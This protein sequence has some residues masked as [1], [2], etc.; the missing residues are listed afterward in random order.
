MTGEA[1][2]PAPDQVIS[3]PQ[4]EPWNKGGLT[5]Q[6]RPL[7]PGDAWTIRVRL[8]LESRK[9]DLAMCNLRIDSK[10]RGCDHVRLQVNALRQ[11]SR[12]SKRFE[13][14][15]ETADALVGRSGVVE[16]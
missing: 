7:K 12:L 10:L 4:R 1:L 13:P 16:H 9:R 3:A 11:P 8:Q 2:M 14:R 15:L 6:K 5:G